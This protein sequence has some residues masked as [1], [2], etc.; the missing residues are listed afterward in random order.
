L[1]LHVD[2]AT[3]AR[4]E[5]WLGQRATASHSATASRSALVE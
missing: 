5:T 4:L 2:A 1:G 3:I